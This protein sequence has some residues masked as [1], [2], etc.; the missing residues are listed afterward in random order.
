[1]ASDRPL[2]PGLDYFQSV[3]G[4]TTDE[5]AFTLDVSR[6]S[7]VYALEGKRKLPQHTRSV[8][9]KWRQVIEHAKAQPGASVPATEFD[10]TPQDHLHFQDLFLKKKMALAELQ[11]KMTLMELYY[12][13]LT[14]GQSVMKHIDF[15]M[16]NDEVASNCNIIH[17]LALARNTK[18]LLK[19]S[20]RNQWELKMKIAGLKG[21]IDV[22]EALLHE[23]S[24]GK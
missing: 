4:W 5:L 20:V 23:R 15:S 11:R 8:L 17:R 19:R 16:L 9:E 1:M 12:P 2:L 6:R 24:I 14:S 13:R 18:A 22:L 21:E 3:L 7:V 10:I